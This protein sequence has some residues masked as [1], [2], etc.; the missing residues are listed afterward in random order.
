MLEIIYN[1]SLKNLSFWQRKLDTHH[2]SGIH[3]HDD[4][5]LYYMLQGSTTYF[6]ADEIF[7]V[8]QGNFVLIPKQV[9]HKTDNINCT[10]NERIL[11]SFTNNTFPASTNKILD[12]LCHCK[13]ISV[14]IQ[15]LTALEDIIYKIKNEHDYS[16]KNSDLMIDLYIM[17]LLTLLSRYKFDCTPLY[18]STDKIILSVSDY[19]K[20][21]YNEDITLE[22]LSKKFVISKNFLSKKFKTITGIG[23]NEFITYIRMTNAEKLLKTTDYPITKI[24]NMCG[25]ND[26]NYFS[27]VFKKIYGITP[28]KFSKKFHI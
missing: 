21:N 23:L 8:N 5:E 16:K 25:Y 1:D 15:K 14:P 3:K 19:I 12:E 6:I 2:I 28:L 13:L 10:N 4:Y 20:E 24:A 11:I 7:E 17:E 27:T 26:S 22:F 18:K 9:F